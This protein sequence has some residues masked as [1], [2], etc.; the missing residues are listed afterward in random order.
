[1]GRGWESPGDFIG[2]RAEMYNSL[3]AMANVQARCMS[4]AYAPS[5]LFDVLLYHFSR[6]ILD[7]RG[8][9]KA[10]QTFKLGALHCSLQNIHAE[11]IR[12]VQ[13][14]CVDIIVTYK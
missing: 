5:K 14:A 6:E 1:M 4:S 2:S 3:S 7:S 9:C 11:S 8:S 13:D 12:V 10:D